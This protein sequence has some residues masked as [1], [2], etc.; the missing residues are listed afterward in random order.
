MKKILILPLDVNKKGNFSDA[1]YL[2]ED[3]I[4]QGFGSKGLNNLA[5]EEK[6]LLRKEEAF[7]F[8]YEAN[9]FVNNEETINHYKK[10]WLTNSIYRSNDASLVFSYKQNSGEN[11]NDA[12]FLKVNL[13]AY[14]E[15]RNA[16]KSTLQNLSHKLHT[17][18]NQKNDFNYSQERILTTL[19][20]EII[21]Q[22]KDLENKNS[23]LTKIFQKNNVTAI[24]YQNTCNSKTITL[25]A[26]KN[27]NT[28]YFEYSTTAIAKET[29][30]L[31][32]DEKPFIAFKKNNKWFKSELK[33]DF[34]YN[35]GICPDGNIVSA[36]E[37]NDFNEKIVEH[38][39]FSY[40]NKTQQEYYQIEKEVKKTLNNPFYKD[41]KLN[42]TTWIEPQ[43]NE[44]PKNVYL[45]GKIPSNIQLFSSKIFKNFEENKPAD[46]TIDIKVFKNGKI[47][48]Q[49][50]VNPN[51]LKEFEDKWKSE[52]KKRGLEVN[53][54]ALRKQ[55]H[56]DIENLARENKELSFYEKF[57]QS[58]KALLFE[59]IGSY[60]E[61]IA[62]TQKIGKNVWA[63]GTINESTWHTTEEFATENKQWPKY[64]QFSPVIAGV[65]DGVIDE[66]V[67]IPM[68]IKG[69]YEIVID[70]EKQKGLKAMFTKDGMVNLYEGL[71]T[72]V[73]DTY[74]D[75]EKG[76]HFVGQTTVSVISMMSGVGLFSKV[77]K[78]DEVVETATDLEKVI[79]DAK[80]TKFLDKVKKTERHV[81]TD[82]AIKELTE[83]VGGERLS[84]AVEELTD[85]TEN[86]VKNGKK[87]T[88]QEIKA[89][90]KRGNDFNEKVRLLDPPKYDFHEITVEHIIDGKPK[91]FRLDSYNEGLEIVSRKATDFDNIKLSTFEGYLKELKK[92]YPEGSKITA[93]KYPYL[94]DKVLKGKLKLEVPESNKLSTKLKE[95]QE[96]SKKYEIEIIFEKE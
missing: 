63:Q 88:W 18:L 78:L 71:K 80:T 15:L 3:L 96:L 46:I 60:V 19:E 59:N 56:L 16:S 28:I 8:Y 34:L 86:A 11:T 17:E 38:I 69:V 40:L 4:P 32:L 20:Q 5:E 61:A 74:N 49:N 89:F 53:I 70:E 87:F 42:V 75:P 90:F 31:A 36:E 7:P 22:R 85:L 58:T 95:F 6:N 30:G 94:K 77:K 91:K 21:M 2:K 35:N 25:Y 76:E 55:V 45:D 41:V 14:E 68:A 10:F 50:K 67:G 82:K 12:L 57:I 13:Y 52:A 73:K 54:A 66:I 92:K 27:Q 47:V 44:Y 29:T 39:D 62:A 43:T 26:Y 48:I 24:F 65:E 1:Y 64:C 79:P 83:E 33:I 37:I 93:P 72:E 51:Y 81:E 9:S 23:F 84:E